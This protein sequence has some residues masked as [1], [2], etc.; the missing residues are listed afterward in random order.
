VRK[1]RRIRDH[2]GHHDQIGGVLHELAGIA[3]V[4]MIVVGP[5][6][7]DQVGLP[8]ANLA[9][10]LLADLQRGHQFGV[11]VV[12]HLVF[13]D[14]QPAGR[15]FGLGP[16]TIGQHAAAL[17]VVP[18]VA[19]RDR[20]ELHLV[21]HGGIERRRAAHFDV[22]VVRVRPNAQNAQG[23]DRL[24]LHRSSH[25]Q[26]QNA[27]EKK[28]TGGAH[29]VFSVCPAGIPRRCAPAPRYQ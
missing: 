24:G 25:Y 17:R 15:L 26:N 22:A 6:R 13:G 29:K 14:A 12:E 3:M 23:P 7:K 9:D 27:C 2:V 11:V 20:E 1:R 21:A 16:A 5:G 28:Q 19:V 10:D 4:R 8:L 18:G